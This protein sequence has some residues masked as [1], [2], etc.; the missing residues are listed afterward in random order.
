[1]QESIDKALS[2]LNQIQGLPAVALVF[3]SCI[4]IGYAWKFIPAKW[5]PNEAIPV[6]V[7]LWGAFCQS[8]LADARVSSMPLRVWIVRNV[9]VGLAIGFIAWMTHNLIL[10]KIEDWLSAKFP[11]VDRLLNKPQEPPKP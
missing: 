4:V 1:M 8:M 11:L 2:V 10:S 5:F 9:L 6:I 7:I 3:V